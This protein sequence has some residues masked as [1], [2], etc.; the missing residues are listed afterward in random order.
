MIT[1]RPGRMRRCPATPRHRG[2]RAL[3]GAPQ[4]PGA[5]V[6]A[7]LM[8]GHCLATICM[9]EAEGRRNAEPSFGRLALRYLFSSRT[10][11]D[12]G[13]AAPSAVAGASCGKSR[14]T[15]KAEIFAGQAA[16][17]APVWSRRVDLGLG[18]RHDVFS[19]GTKFVVVRGRVA[20]HPPR[21]IFGNDGS[22][23]YVL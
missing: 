23:W 19:P 6:L 20:P 9:C 7:F 12:P 11:P 10:P 2:F 16:E 3:R 18:L 22:C 15:R 14:S 4:P 1:L 17:A 13:D 21:A 8:F 5:I